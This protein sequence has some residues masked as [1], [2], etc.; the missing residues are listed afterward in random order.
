MAAAIG[1][2]GHTRSYRLKN[3]ALNLR[4][5]PIPSN[6]IHG[7]ACSTCWPHKKSR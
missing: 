3:R 6:R 5:I 7:Y 1:D 4:M 2:R